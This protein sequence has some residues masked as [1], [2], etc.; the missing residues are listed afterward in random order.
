MNIHAVKIFVYICIIMNLSS[1]I[2][3]DD[4]FFIYFKYFK[5]SFIWNNFEKWVSLTWIHNLHIIPIENSSYKEI[6]VI[7]HIPLTIQWI[8]CSDNSYLHLSSKL[9]LFKLYYVWCSNAISFQE[10]VWAKLVFKMGT[11]NFYIVQ[12]IR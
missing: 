8:I 11:H 1:M 12:K 5:C 9:I 7:V 10:T 4:F 3:D 6:K 2:S